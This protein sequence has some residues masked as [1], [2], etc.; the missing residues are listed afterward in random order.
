MKTQWHIFFLA[1][2]AAFI[3]QQTNLP[4][5]SS[6]LTENYRHTRLFAHGFPSYILICIPITDCL[7]VVFHNTVF[8]SQVVQLNCKCLFCSYI[9]F[10]V[11]FLILGLLV[12]GVICLNS[13]PLDSDFRMSRSGFRRC[14]NTG[15]NDNP[16]RDFRLKIH[17]DA[18]PNSSLVEL[19]SQASVFCYQ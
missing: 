1:P 12:L 8:L 18:L 5:L 17:L 16:L 6:I 9:I 15:I 7:G 14:C 19:L 11:S 2:S 4:E 3:V 13:W 10:C